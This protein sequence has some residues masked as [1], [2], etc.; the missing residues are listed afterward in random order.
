MPYV[1]VVYD[2]FPIHIPPATFNY[3]WASTVMHNMIVHVFS[4]KEPLHSHKHDIH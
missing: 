3:S 2:V 1:L 4:K